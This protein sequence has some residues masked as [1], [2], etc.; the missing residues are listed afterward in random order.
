MEFE[1]LKKRHSVRRFTSE[2]IDPKIIDRL[3]SKA[4]LLNE[5]HGLSIQ[6]VYDEPEAFGSSRLARY[7]KFENVTDYICLIGPK[8]KGIEVLI[9][10]VGQCMLLYAFSLGLDTCW[11][12]MT[13]NRKKI[14]VNLRD[15]DKIFAVIAIGY[16]ID[17]GKQSR[18]EKPMKISPEYEKAPEWFQR[19]VDFAL[20]GPSALNQ[21]KF[22]FRWK[23][24]NRVKA[25]SG[26]G[27]YTKIDLGIAMYCFSLGAGEEIKIEWE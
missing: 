7:G 14:P 8:R 3:A 23:G 21:Q 20:H 9:G 13:F 15:D 22:R 5:H 27:F 24:E 26:V 12:G 19:G 25:V 18:N 11:V 6:V 10:M 17:H 4:A 1:T 2:R 16:G